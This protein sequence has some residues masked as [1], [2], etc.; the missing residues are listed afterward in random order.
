MSTPQGSLEVHIAASDIAHK[1]GWD[2]A[3]SG[4][5]LS[6]AYAWWAK[7]IFTLEKA[8]PV[9]VD[10]GAWSLQSKKVQPTAL[11][12]LQRTLHTIDMTTNPVRFAVLPDVVGS[13]S[14][15]VRMMTDILT[16]PGVC[17]DAR[18]GTPFQAKTLH[19]WAVVVSEGFKPDELRALL[20]M[21]EQRTGHPPW[22]FIGGKTHGFKV[23]AV[24]T[25]GFW[26][27]EVPVHVGKVHKLNDLIHF[28]KEPNVVSVDT[29][30][31]SRPP[32][33][34]Y[35]R[36]LTK[37]LA[38]FQAWIGGKQPTLDGWTVTV[39][40]SPENWPCPRCKAAKGEPCVWGVTH[41]RGAFHADRKR[42]AAK[43]TKGDA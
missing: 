31:F 24:R 32:T 22:V 15:S 43:A 19:P 35:R 38:D 34:S 3:F 23:G 28:F 8:W 10:N 37:R 42:A 18:Q 40:S 16:D 9:I 41:S 11:E 36:N 1:E 4:W 12:M 21:A 33:D 29:S 14:A 7:K 6:P 27:P 13:W 25:V 26:F 39:K 2:Y 30:T 20:M 5:V 17:F